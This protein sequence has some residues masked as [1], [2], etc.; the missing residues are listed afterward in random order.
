M[1]IYLPI[2][3]PVRENAMTI[4][5]DTAHLHQYN[6]IISV[7]ECYINI[8]RTNKKVNFAIFKSSLGLQGDVFL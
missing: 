5:S 8:S 3:S 1:N 6:Y 7:S 2:P 4:V